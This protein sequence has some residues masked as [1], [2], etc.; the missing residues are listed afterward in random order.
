MLDAQKWIEDAFGRWGWRQ[1]AIAASILALAVVAVEAARMI[2]RVGDRAE[3]FLPAP[4]KPVVL[5]RWLNRDDPRGFVHI[6]RRGLASA[7]QA[8]DLAWISGSAISIRSAPLEWQLAGKA[9]YNMTDVLARYVKRV[10]D[11]P[12]RV[13]EYL[14]QGARTGDIRRAVLNATRQREIDA[15]ILEFNPIWYF[16]EYLEY[17][18]S[19]QR[20]EILREPGATAFDWSMAVR[21]LRPSEIGFEA[22]GVALPSVR[23]RSSLLG[24]KMFHDRLAFPFVKSGEGAAR[25]GAMV[26]TWQAMFFPMRPSTARNITSVMWMSNLADDT[27]ASQLLEAN[28]RSLAATG[29]PVVLFVPPI[30]PTVKSDAAAVAQ[31]NAIVG[32]LQ[33]VVAKVG[34]ANVTLHTQSIWDAPQ[35]FEHRDIYHLKHG[36][37]VIDLVVNLLG[38][39]TGKAIEKNDTK[40]VYKSP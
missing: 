24:G 40:A 20:A 30:N 4:G 2:F 17:T 26:G 31:V 28:V 7:G 33:R 5:R 12:I 15:Y 35:P 21:I 36:Q 19:R 13:H 10:G 14:I 16:N 8:F 9:A 18:L 23:D 37:G 34:A 3:A 22:L 11:Q 1:L 32:Q 38:K 29:K 39:A 6:P 27:I 25:D